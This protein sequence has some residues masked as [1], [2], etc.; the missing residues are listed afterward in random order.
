MV[1]NFA[2]FRK[3]NFC[4]II[5][6]NWNSYEYLVNCLHSIRKGTSCKYEVIVIDNFS[7][8]EEQQ[9]LLDIPGIKLICN[10]KNLGFAVANNQGFEEAK[11][12]FIFMLNPD[13]VVLDKAVDELVSFLI[14]HDDIDAAAPKLYYS[15]KMDYHPSVKKF[16]SPFSQFL[17][18]IPF[19]KIVR[20]WWS[21]F[22]FGTG[23]GDVVTL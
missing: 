9:L 4:S 23:V 16:P 2:E 19:S 7:S 3:K 14:E 20:D 1:E 11:G 13:T 15:E 22:T 8:L 12:D 21:F 10:S 17:Q 5:I 6:V 18:M